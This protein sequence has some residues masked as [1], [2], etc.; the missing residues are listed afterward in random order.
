MVYSNHPDTILIIY[1][2][3]VIIIIK[4]PKKNEFSMSF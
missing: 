3:K 1:W 2:I 4:N